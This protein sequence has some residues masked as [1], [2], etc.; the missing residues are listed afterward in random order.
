MTKGGFGNETSREIRGGVSSGCGVATEWLRSIARGF[1]K[2]ALCRRDRVSV[3]G[4]AGQVRFRVQSSGF[5]VQGSGFRAQG[6]G[7]RV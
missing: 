3:P 5:R 7:F 2:G 6:S 1:K 4:W